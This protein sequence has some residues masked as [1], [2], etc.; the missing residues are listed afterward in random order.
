[1]TLLLP[2]PNAAVSLPVTF[3]WNR[4]GLSGDTYKVVIY[5]YDLREWFWTTGNPA[6]VGSYTLQSLLTGMV[7]GRSYYWLVSVFRGTD[8]FGYSFYMNGVKFQSSAAT[9]PA[10]DLSQLPA[11]VGDLSRP[12]APP[13]RAP[14][15]GNIA[16]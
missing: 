13:S 1:M 14:P 11:P 9:A 15:G 3:T 4:R 5:D 6:D 10:G 2:K 7:Y 16:P 12:P 8:S